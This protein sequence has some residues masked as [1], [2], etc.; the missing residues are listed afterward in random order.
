MKHFVLSTLTAAALALSSHTVRAA[1]EVT[2]LF[3][4]PDFLPAFAP[5][6]LA[7]A[8]GYFTG[9]GLDVSFASARAA[10]MSPR[11]SPSATPIW[12]A[13]SATRRSSC[14]PTGWIFAAWRCWAG[15]A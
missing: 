6:Q 1:E 13:A 15:A 3:P 7:K 10:R 14:A 5:F 4:A 9:A 11:R 8:K 2:Y 12:A